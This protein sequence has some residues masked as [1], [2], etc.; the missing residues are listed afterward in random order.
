MAETTGVSDRAAWGAAVAVCAALVL[1]GC[2]GPAVTA[3]GAPAGR[4]S[5][6]PFRATL[7]LRQDFGVASGRGVCGKEAQLT[8]GFGCFRED[9]TQYHGTPLPERTPSPTRLEVA[10]TRVLVGLDH[11]VL[12]N[13][14][15]GLRA[16]L[17]AR[18]LG[19]RQDGAAAPVPSIFHGEV[20]VA[21][22]FGAAPFARDGLRW[23][24][25]LSGGT[26]QVDTAWRVHVDEDTSAP[27]AVVQPN[28]PAAQTLDVYRKSG[29]GFAGGGVT[30]AVGF[31]ER[32]AVFVE[33]TG[34]L[35]FPSEGAAVSPVIG[36]EH[37]F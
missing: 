35:L 14:A 20:R 22:W 16:G 13:L 19:P 28:N 8:G 17:A 26:A 9:G 34:M 36:Y 30:L 33:V 5:V 29:T 32:A 12:Q 11:V 7:A 4:A 18:G 24:V 27:P 1:A 37:A 15:I 31:L 25:F 2:A 10:T 21:W 6:R 3:K 23:G